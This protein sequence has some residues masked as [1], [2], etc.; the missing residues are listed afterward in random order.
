MGEI[1]CFTKERF[2]IFLIQNLFMSDIQSNAQEIRWVPIFWSVRFL[3]ALKNKMTQ[4]SE[5]N[6]S[7]RI[8]LELDCNKI[9]YWHAGASSEYKY[10]SILDSYF[11]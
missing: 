7:S 3:L 6:R 4:P 1:M 8:S 5:R 11:W 9:S 2:C 10:G